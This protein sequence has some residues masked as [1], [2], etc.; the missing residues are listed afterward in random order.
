VSGTSPSRCRCSFLCV[1]CLLFW[2][3]SSAWK[4]WLPLSSVAST[5]V[6]WLSLSS[7]IDLCSRPFGIFISLCLCCSCNTGAC[8]CIWRG[9][10][11][12][13]L[14]GCHVW[15]NVKSR[16]HESS[17]VPYHPEFVYPCPIN[18]GCSCFSTCFSLDSF[19]AASTPSKTL[20]D[21][22]RSTGHVQAPAYNSQQVPRLLTGKPLS[23]PFD[24]S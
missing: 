1:F 12:L 8:R 10:A 3:C 24:L 15:K 14:G 6:F 23:F 21:T 11:R 13:C 20:T 16:R 7:R 18:T 22:H 5:G 4:R 19:V 2:T 9:F 17:R